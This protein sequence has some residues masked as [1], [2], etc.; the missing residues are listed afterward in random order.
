MKTT[1]HLATLAI[2][3]LPTLASAKGPTF[4][5]ECNGGVNRG[6]Y[7]IDADAKGH[8]WVNG[9][10]VNLAPGNWEGGYHGATFNITPD[11]SGTYIS[12]S[13]NWGEEGVCNMTANRDCGP[14]AA[15][16]PQT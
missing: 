2:V 12:W 1:F 8:L 9:H 16:I 10:R 3:A 7:N 6:G 4:A 11:N 15:L 5:A 13:N 14:D